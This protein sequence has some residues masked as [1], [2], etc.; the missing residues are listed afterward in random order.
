MPNMLNSSGAIER[1]MRA[2]NGVSA[3][4]R[5]MNQLNSSGAIERVMR[6][7]NGLSAV[8]RAMNQLNSSGAIERVMRAQNTVSV[9]ERAMNQLN[10]SGAIV[11]VLSQNKAS[12]P[13]RLLKA[14]PE[15]SELYENVIDQLDP[16]SVEEIIDDIVQKTTESELENYEKEQSEAQSL[17]A[18]PNKDDEWIDPIRYAAFQKSAEWLTRLQELY[19]TYSERAI[20]GLNG[21]AQKIFIR[22]LTQSLSFM[23][24]MTCG[25]VGFV[26]ALLATG[27]VEF[28]SEERMNKLSPS[29]ISGIRTNCPTCYAVPGMWCITVRGSAPGSPTNKLHKSRMS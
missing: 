4:E 24:I 12:Q 27:T 1:V 15:I 28:I 8:E 2:Q 5:A 23:L 22:V 20:R 9:V 18:H 7:Q 21:I 3:V 19:P 13:I 16:S 26:F 14:A 25:P 17:T 29:A 10:S 6:A 11:W